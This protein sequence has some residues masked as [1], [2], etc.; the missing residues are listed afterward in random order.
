MGKHSAK[1]FDTKDNNRIK[2]T[3]KK[4]KK[5]NFG[6]FFL[7]I[8][9][10]AVICVLG[11]IVYKFYPNIIEK[12]ENK[13]TE[14]E[15]SNITSLSSMMAKDDEKSKFETKKIE[16]T[17]LSLGH[18][19]VNYNNSITLTEF[20][21]FNEG[22]TDQP[23]FNFTFSLLDENDDVIID[24]DL[25]S[26]EVISANGKRHFNLIASRDVSNATDFKVEVK[27]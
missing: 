15:S 21:I 6:K 5:F 25:S 14:N 13:N 7:I 9:L 3:R 26:K 27:K 12:T 8:L 1:R 4:K 22:S 10:L 11:F 24:Y 19:F 17:D 18:L 23:I 16:G 20:E 2:S